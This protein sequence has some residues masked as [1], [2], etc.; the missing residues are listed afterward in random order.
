MTITGGSDNFFPRRPWDAWHPADVTEL[1]GRVREVERLL[2]VV[3]VLRASEGYPVPRQVLLERI[4][5]YRDATVDHESVKRMMA[6]DRN[7][8]REIGFQIDDV[9]GDGDTSAFVLRDAA[10]RLPLDL[11][12]REQNL[13]TWVMAAAGSV[14]AEGALSSVPGDLSGLLGHMPRNFDLVQAAIASRRLLVIER[15]GKVTDFAPG[16]LASWYGR[17]FVIGRFGGEDVLKAPRLDRLE[18]LE[19]GGPM[20][21]PPVVV[22][23]DQY[24]DQTAWDKHEP[25]TAVLRCRTADKAAIGSWFAR[26]EVADHE[27]GTTTFTLA[28]RNEE[29]LV[30]RVIGLT[31]VVWI[32]SPPS[33]VTALREQVLSVVG[34]QP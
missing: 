24:L 13:L 1:S 5:E 19:L 20:T 32:E 7:R 6:N 8:L 11:D 25:R 29:N 17:W 14:A 34:E 23:P 26:A 2:Q 16:R 21:D 31:G 28:Y 15:D 10:W 30:T 18:V 27:D 12:A 33:A 9:A 22:D 3:T 4:P